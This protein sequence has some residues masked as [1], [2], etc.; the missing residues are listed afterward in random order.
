MKKF[1]LYIIPFR[2]VFNIKAQLPAEN[3]TWQYGKGNDDIVLIFSGVWKS[4]SD[5]ANYESFSS[6]IIK[7][8]NAGVKISPIDSGYYWGSILFREFQYAPYYDCFK[9]YANIENYAGVA[10]LKDIPTG[11]YSITLRSKVMNYEKIGTFSITG[12]DSL[13][14]KDSTQ[15]I[16]T[17]HLIQIQ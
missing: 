14:I 17:N 5:T 3:I 10:L 7:T 4:Y 9:N 11:N 2:I 1:I 13:I 6:Q 12:K 15:H 8:I 16:Y